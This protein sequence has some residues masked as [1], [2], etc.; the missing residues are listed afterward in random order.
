MCGITGW[1]DWKTDVREHA[2]TL[3]D[4]TASLVHRGPDASGEWFS[5]RA[6]LGH[7]RLSIID[8]ANGAQ[9]MVR[10]ARGR[11]FVIVYNGELY[12]T[13][14]LRRELE[15]LG[16]TFETHCDTE[17]L[18]LA[19]IEWGPSCLDRLNGIFAF[20]VWDEEEQTLFLARDRIGVKPLFFAR[21]GSAFLF[22][23]E[24]KAI[25]A[26]PLVTREVPVG[27]FEELFFLGPARTPGS[28]VFRQIE[29]LEPGWCLQH[30][31]GGT[32]KRRY[33]SLESRPHEDSFDRTVERVREL[34][35]DAVTRQLVSDVPVG[36]MV[37]GGL[38]SS[39]IT[40]IAAGVLADGGKGPLDTYSL[41]F[42]DNSVHF[43]P[44]DYVP[45]E[46]TPWVKR[47]TEHL[48]T[49]HHLIVLDTAELTSHLTDSLR[50]R[51]LPGGWEVESSLLLFCR[52]IKKRSTVVLSGETADEIF[53]GYRWF[54]QDGDYEVE[55][56]PWVRMIAERKELLSPE[57]QSAIR[58]EETV[59]EHYRRTVAGCPDLPGEDP[60]EAR[61]RRMFH[62]NFARW[63]PMM[64]DRKDRASMAQGL[65]VRVPFCDHRIVE[66]L[67]NVPWSMKNAGG[68]GKGL[69]RHAMR[70]I[71]PDDV[72]WRPKSPFPT[73][74]NPQYLRRV[75]E[76][77]VERLR[78]PSSPLRPLLNM[79]ALDR[80]L[81]APESEAT[82]R[83]WFG[84][85]AKDAQFLAYLYQIDLWMTEYRVSL[86]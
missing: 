36:T 9:P 3:R 40:A 26:H 74:H 14:E 31:R 42:V 76:L 54:H 21:I 27:A 70:G 62:I 11:T 56:F 34:V 69:L 46:D 18:L 2:R 47:V 65:E 45:D 17:V 58:P 64:L 43:R 39:S 23:S 24:I 71:L 10:R 72:L 6:A 8:P 44:T 51:D 67:W 78:Q 48:K 5:A 35:V 53:G 61:R 63:L 60:A 77:L 83:H 79:P 50:S 81:E 68:V 12:N 1:I 13:P 80:L 37:S 19:F 38:D 41:D 25:L 84:M 57:L 15:A 55:R 59:A 32:D 66:Y 33:W 85:F 73:T 7:R 16:W 20:A 75:K 49:R 82:Q 28:G 52:E 29:E 4:M 86:V 30:H 22:G